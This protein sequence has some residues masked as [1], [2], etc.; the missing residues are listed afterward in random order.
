MMEKFVR[1]VIFIVI[2]SGNNR[3][4]STSKIKKITAIKKN[5][6][7]KGIRA[8]DFG[9]N[10][11]SNGDLFSRSMKVFFEIVLAIIIIIILIVKVII[12]I[13][14]TV[15]IIYTKFS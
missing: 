15:I 10:P 12:A 5:C 2:T 4:I 11:H 7:E 1:L 13:R 8:D 6:K 9:S 3:V 14:D